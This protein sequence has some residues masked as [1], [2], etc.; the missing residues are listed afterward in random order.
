MG[1]HDLRLEIGSDFQPPCKLQLLV[2]KLTCTQV[3][4]YILY[5][6]QWIALL[7]APFQGQIYDSLAVYCNIYVI[8]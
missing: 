7:C 1:F 8:V 4:Q 2:K 5:E 3:C 6:T